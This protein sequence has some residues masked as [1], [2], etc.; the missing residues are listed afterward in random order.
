MELKRIGF[1]GTGIMGEAMAFH[2]MEA[3]YELSVYN[4]TKAKADRLVEHG[5]KWC[6]TPAECA[7]NQDVVISIVG[8]PKDVEEVYFGEQG[9]FNGVKEGAYLID[10]T[11]SSPALAQC[12]FQEAKE[13]GLHAMDAP[14]TGGDTGAK[15]G[16]LSILAGGEQEDFDAALPVFQAMGK[17]IRYM[18]E[19]G[20]GQKT[21]LCNQIA[22]A[23]ALAGACEALS[24]AKG[25]GLDGEEVLAAIS[26]GA[27]GSFQLSNV[28]A[29]GLREDWDPGFMLKHFI[30]D[31][32]LSQEAAL[33]CGLNL[34]VLSQVLK[35]SLSLEEQGKGD[36]GTQALMEY[37]F[38]A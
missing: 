9:I 10:M 5:A 4:R 38:K 37:Y 3:G 31:M 14:V 16:T 27:A 6:G 1:I 13:R 24:Y 19:A 12:I 18:G 8:Y 35:E 26:G 7:R 11:T 34:E 22:I 28:A 36:L 2:L 23:G 21:K 15:A 25:C 17:N 33:G 29:K 20:A 32:K 30:K